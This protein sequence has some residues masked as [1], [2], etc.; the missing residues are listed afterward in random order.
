[1]LSR[2][3]Q[4]NSIWKTQQEKHPRSGHHSNSCWLSL[5]LKLLR[6]HFSSFLWGAPGTSAQSPLKLPYIDKHSAFVGFSIQLKPVCFHTVA[7]SCLD[8]ATMVYSC[9]ELATFTFLGVWSQ[10]ARPLLPG[11]L[12]YLQHQ[13]QSLSCANLETNSACTASPSD[14]LKWATDERHTQLSKIE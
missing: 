10:P 11:T 6:F 1:M 13:D 2:T 14:F 8:L 5:H 7:F 9:Q 4:P 3:F 12:S